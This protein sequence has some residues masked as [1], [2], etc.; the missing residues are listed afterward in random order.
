MEIDRPT[1]MQVPHRER[2]GDRKEGPSCMGKIEA[3]KP[4]VTVT[5]RS[6]SLCSVFLYL[7]AARREFSSRDTIKPSRHVAR[8]RRTKIKRRPCTHAAARIETENA[9]SDYLYSVE[10]LSQF[11]LVVKFVAC[12]S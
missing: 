2:G 11:T 8:L 4:L 7:L 1:E 9:R 12:L 6:A 10:K 5:K 3:T